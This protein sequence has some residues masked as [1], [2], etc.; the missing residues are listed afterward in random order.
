[1]TAGAHEKGINVNRTSW[2]LV[3]TGMAATALVAGTAVASTPPTSTPDDAPFDSEPG[4]AVAAVDL[5]ALDPT[6]VRLD[7]RATLNADFLVDDIP[8][9][10]LSD[11]ANG[12]T[13]PYEGHV[14]P[15]FSGIVAN[16]DRSFW[17]MPD[18]GFGTIE[19]SADFLLRLY[20]ITPDWETAGG[21]AGEIFVNDFISLRDPNNVIGFPIVNEDTPERLLTGS[22]L[23]IE[24][25]QR[26][27]GGTFWIGDE[28][29][30]FIVHFDPDGVL[31]DAPIEP[32][33]GMSP[34]NPHLAGAAPLVERRRGFEAM[35]MSPDGTKLFPIVEGFLTDDE[36]QL[37]R[38]IYEVDVATGEYTDRS[39]QMHTE[40]PAN[41]V[42]DAQALD[43]NRLLII[44][45]DGFQWVDSAF[46]RLYVLD[47]SAPDEEGFVSK[48]HALNL[49]WIANP[50]GIGEG[51]PEDGFGLGPVFAFPLE[52]VETLVVLG[53]GRLL[54]ANDN[55][56]PGGNGRIPGTPD[57][58]E[59]IILSAVAEAPPPST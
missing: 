4:S 16:D 10:D 46:K 57:D 21:G 24:S 7:A 26:A 19:N 27:P 9:G 3:L 1:M 53:G 31:L 56:Y 11:P 54:V 34:Q 40:T 59:M 32:P 37:R 28:F 33:F 30:P 52:S 39:W 42:A 44:E 18:N 20:H 6:T 5:G 58:T 47:L 48:H 23:D 14:V 29:G 50:D 13:P 12:R 25:V 15:G 43:D 35:A 55:N 45:R 49:M 36:D 41:L 38:Y 2:V 8:T 17:A 51:R 22:D